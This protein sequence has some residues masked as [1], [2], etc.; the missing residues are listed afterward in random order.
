M[1]SPRRIA[2]VGPFPPIRGG[3]ARHT[4]ALTRALAAQGPHEVRGWSFYRQYPRLLYPGADERDPAAQPHAAEATLGGTNPLSWAATA[5]QVRAWSPDLLVM[6][7]WTFFLAPALGSVARAARPT[8][9]CMIVHNAFDHESAGWKDR[10]MRWQLAA[11]DRFVTHNNALARELATRFPGTPARVFPHPVYDDFPAPL[12]TLPRRKP[13]ELLFF[14]LVRPYKG[15]D[16]LLDALA[17]LGR[18]DIA[19]TVAGEVWGNPD[20]TRRRIADL[21]LTDTVELIPRFVSDA[22]AA[23]YFHR[24]DAIVL[25]Y[26]TVTGSGVVANAYHYGRPVIASDLPGFA[27]IVTDGET[28]W[29]FPPEDAQALAALIGGLDRDKAAAAGTRAKALGDTLSWDRLAEVVLD[30]GPAS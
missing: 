5:R 14:G 24:A 16:I 3:I 1:T 21:G 15:L 17:R 29:L 18:Q 23:E 27:E 6:P 19:L 10:V 7:A 25:P 8:D 22:E 20:D 28:G 12:G 26:R 13:L 11:A 30:Q 9:C 4:A 2:V